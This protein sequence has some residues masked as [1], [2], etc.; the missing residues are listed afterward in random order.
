METSS[1]PL[2]SPADLTKMKE[3]I[4]ASLS[5]IYDLAP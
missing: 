3:E 2:L 4:K 1:R 5:V